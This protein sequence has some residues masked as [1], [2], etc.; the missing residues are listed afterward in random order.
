MASLFKLAFLPAMFL[1]LAFPGQVVVVYA[2]LGEGNEQVGA[3]VPQSDWN[4]CVCHFLLRHLHFYIQR[5]T[6]QYKDVYIV[7]TQV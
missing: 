3:V 6:D 2:A 1:G 5:F 4:L 7:R